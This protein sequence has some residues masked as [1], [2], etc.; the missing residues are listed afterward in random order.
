MSSKEDQIIDGIVVKE[1]PI[2]DHI[3]RVSM[4]KLRLRDNGHHTRGIQSKRFKDGH[5]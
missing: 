4:E 5:S 3:L 1:T 2:D